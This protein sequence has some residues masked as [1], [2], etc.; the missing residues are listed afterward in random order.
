MQIIVSIIATRAT[1][2]A[3]VGAATIDIMSAIRR[4]CFLP[5]PSNK[6]VSMVVELQARRY[7]FDLFHFYKG[8]WLSVKSPCCTC[9]ATLYM[10]HEN[11]D[12][13]INKTVFELY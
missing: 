12:L 1:S 3:A 6:K 7:I 11:G 13:K 10:V 4:Y 9:L 8:G 5:T 2:G